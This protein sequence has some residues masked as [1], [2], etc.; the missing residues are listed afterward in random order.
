MKR[1][2]S[3]LLSLSII[4]SSAAAFA[5]PSDIP[6]DKRPLAVNAEEIDSAIETFKADLAKKN[7]YDKIVEDYLTL[8]DLSLLMFDTRQLN[9]AEIEKYNYDF[10]ISYSKEELDKNY[11]DTL[12][13][14]KKIDLAIKSILES[15]YADKFK[16][17]WGEERTAMIESIDEEIDSSYKD[18]YDRYYELLDN[19]ADGVEFARL[20]KEIIAD[21]IGGYI[22]E[23]E[24]AEESENSE[25]KTLTHYGATSEQLWDYCNEVY[26]YYYHINKFKNYATHFGISDIDGSVAVEKPLQ[27]LS[28]VGEIAPLLKT[29]Y[30]YL[31][32]NNL[33][34]YDDSGNY[35]AGTTYSLATYG[36]SDVVVAGDKESVF[37]T[38]IHEFGHFQCFL[39]DEFNREDAYFGQNDYFPITEFDSQTLELLATSFYDRFYGD[40]ADAMKFRTIVNSLMLLST[41]AQSAAFE[42]SLYDPEVLEL[43]DEE[44]DEYL[45]NYFGDNWYEVCGFFF[46]HRMVYITYSLA[47]FD[48]AQLYALY[49]KD[50]DAAVEKYIEACSIRGDTYTDATHKLGFVSAFDE[51]AYDYLLEITDDIFE[52]E[53]GINYETAL[54]YFEN[55]TYLGVLFPTAQRVSVNGGEAK[56]LF[57]YNSSGYNYIGI[58]D[59]AMLL[60]GTDKEFDVEYDADTF[61]VNI[62]PDKPYTVTGAE[63]KNEVTPVETAG[64]KAAGTSAL[65]YDGNPFN[66]NGAVFVNGYNCY[67]LRG[68]ADSGVLGITVDYDAE[69]DVVMI[70]TE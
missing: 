47:M 35:Y 59:L 18:F 4:I 25:D 2:I 64:Q 69:N 31:I 48:A 12:E 45:A 57:A 24:E 9:M 17:R 55:G 63:M 11:D 5:A 52:K 66:Y 34:S 26:D 30:D 54:D 6:L 51:G 60:S 44:L 16:E 19:G 27:E 53:Y 56:T 1:V 41:S 50:A 29:A 42:M 37:T 61:T 49:L 39:N 70:F 14:E 13:Y 62:I 36:D 22:E 15:D 20:L 38:M 21:T 32:R 7:N 23:P 67:L 10:D 28:F 46:I 65:L 68:L 58:R 43:S 3:I 40:N 33:L 8:V